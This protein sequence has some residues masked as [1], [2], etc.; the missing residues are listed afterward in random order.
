MLAEVADTIAAEDITAAEDTT[1]AEDIT[2]T[3]DTMLA[4]ATTVEVPA[5]EDGVVI[6]AT[7]AVTVRDLIIK[8][9]T[10]VYIMLILYYFNNRGIVATCYNFL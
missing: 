6:P 4:E 3:A 5:A 1:A 2:A 10:M 9:D 7:K 8:E